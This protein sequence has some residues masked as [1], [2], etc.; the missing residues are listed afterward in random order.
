M[1]AL[2]L[3][4]LLSVSVSGLLIGVAIKALW[5]FRVLHR[6][7]KRLFHHKWGEGSPESRETPE[8]RKQLERF[9]RDERKWQRREDLSK[10]YPPLRIIFAPLTEVD[11]FVELIGTRAALI[12]LATTGFILVLVVS[13]LAS[14][15]GLNIGD[16]VLIVAWSVVGY[17]SATRSL[18]RQ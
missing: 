7:E 14:P 15:L 11:F 16:P 13:L 5:T 17:R 9:N 6:V 8:F 1:S 2:L 18:K 4:N 10:R 12:L 3:A